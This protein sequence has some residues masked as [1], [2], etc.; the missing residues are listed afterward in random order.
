MYAPNAIS[1]DNI[2]LTS[3]VTISFVK[4]ENHATTADGATFQGT[5]APKE[6]QDGDNWYGVTTAGQVMKAGTGAKVKGYRAYFTGISA[7]AAGAHIS[8]AID[9]DGGTTDLGFV[10]LIDENANDVYTLSGQKV[11]KGGKGIY[12]VNGRKVIIK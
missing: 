7:P 1:K 8:I 9:D 5:Y 3:N 12:I 4:D 6:Y 10:K 11:K 2:E